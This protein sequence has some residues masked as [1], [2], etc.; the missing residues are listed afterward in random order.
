M[1]M[2]HRVGVLF[3]AARY[4]RPGL[5]CGYWFIALSVTFGDSLSSLCRSCDISLRPEGVFQRESQDLPPTL[6]EVA[7]R[8]DDG[9]GKPVKGKPMKKEQKTQR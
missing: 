5:K 8:S 1:K 4:H 7:S 6:G 2:D 3:A 9:E